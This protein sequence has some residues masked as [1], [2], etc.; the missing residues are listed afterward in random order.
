MSK[1]MIAWK[2]RIA[3]LSLGGSSFFFFGAAG[4]NGPTCS[5]SAQHGDVAALYQSVGSHSI[6]AFSDAVLNDATE[7]SDYDEIIR[8]PVTHFLQA[9]WNNW[10]LERVPQDDPFVDAGH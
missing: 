5:N 4:F 3:L 10:V 2:R 6:E 7:H 8:E 1:S 9:L